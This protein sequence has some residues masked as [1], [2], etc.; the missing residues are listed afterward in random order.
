MRQQTIML[1][2]WEWDKNAVQGNKQKH[3]PTFSGEKWTKNESETTLINV[4]WF[5][6]EFV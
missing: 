4:F 5:T 2:E 6:F 3:V 1:D